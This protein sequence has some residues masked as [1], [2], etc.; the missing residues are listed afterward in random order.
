MKE[1]QCMQF[2]KNEKAEV[3]VKEEIEA[4]RVREK[5]GGR[6]GT[7]QEWAGDGGA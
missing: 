4:Q 3:K 6:A 7:W 5:K 2:G 1:E